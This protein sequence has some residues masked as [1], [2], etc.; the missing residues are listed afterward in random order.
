MFRLPINGMAV[1]QTGE[2]V[3]VSSIK[4]ARRSTDRRRRITAA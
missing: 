3:W 4:K 1:D 2:A